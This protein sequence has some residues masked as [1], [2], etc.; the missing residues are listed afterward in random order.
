LGRD[1][2]RTVE[3]GLLVDR[4]ATVFERHLLGRRPTG[5]VL[6]TRPADPKQVRLDRE[7]ER[8]SVSVNERP[9]LRPR[10]GR[11]QMSS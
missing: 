8:L 11:D 1:T 5:P 6:Q 2:P 3:G 10:Q 9:A 4:I 7:R